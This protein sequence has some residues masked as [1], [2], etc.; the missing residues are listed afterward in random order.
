MRRDIKETTKALRHIK[1]HELARCLND[2]NC[3][4]NWTGCTKSDMVQGIADNEHRT[5]EAI[6]SLYGSF[7]KWVEHCDQE[8]E[9]RRAI[10]EK[11]KRFEEAR[12]KN[13]IATRDRLLQIRGALES[14]KRVSKEDREF[15]F[16]R[17]EN[18]IL[19][20]FR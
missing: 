17:L 8:I 6:C 11:V 5:H 20:Y 15:F 19:Y 16:G 3:A 10:R 4:I 13:R 2:L 14:S 12:E 1:A 9:K 18:L 7:E